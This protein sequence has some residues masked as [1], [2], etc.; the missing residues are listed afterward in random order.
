MTGERLNADVEQYLQAAA[1]HVAPPA[2]NSDPLVAGDTPIEHLLRLLGLAANAGDQKDNAEAAEGHAARDA[3]TTEAA[4]L[5]AAQDQ[6]AAAEIGLLSDGADAP[7][8]AT[9]DPTAQMAQQLP[10]VVSA[11]AGAVAGAVGGLLQPLAQ[12]PQQLTQGAQQA[13]QTGMGLAQQAGGSTVAGLDDAG[14]DADP[15]VDDADSAAEDFGDAGGY[16]GG[17]GTGSGTGSGTE[18]VGGSGGGIGGAAPMALLGPPATPS[19]GTAPSSAPTASIP[20]PLHPA[21]APT[22]GPGMAGMP[23]VP[24]AAMQGTAGA[25]RDTRA[26]TRRVAVPP[27]RNGAPVQGRIVTPPVAPVV[28]KVE[29]KPVATR[30]V[31]TPGDKTEG[32]QSA[33]GGPLS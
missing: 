11:V 21:P 2:V 1:A 29:G 7:Q 9:Q 6:Q 4:E 31:I 30:R 14:L 3:K 5:F 18:E 22:A 28:K 17:I 10:Q 33:A 15:W 27:V 25:E 19:P 8:A 20:A 26:D 24:P 12:I 23:M 32:D 13:L 16:G